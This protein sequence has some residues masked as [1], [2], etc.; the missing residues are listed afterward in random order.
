M[1]EIQADPAGQPIRIAVCAALAP[2]ILKMAAGMAPGGVELVPANIA[3]DGDRALGVVAESEFIF[4][5]PEGVPTA[6][7]QAANRVKLIQMLSAGYDNMDSRLALSRGIPIA[8]NGGAN[9]PSVAEHTVL[10]ILALYRHLVDK[11]L[12]VRG[13]G[14]EAA[15]SARKPSRELTG[16]TVGLLGVGFIGRAVAARVRGFETTIIYHDVRRMQPEVEKELGLTY[17]ERAELLKRAD[18]ISLHLPLLP[19]TRHIIGEAELAAMKPEA[20]LVNTARG[21]LVDEQALARALSEQRILGAAL[22]VMAEEP[23]SPDHPLRTMSNCL[24]TPHAAGLTRENWP[25]RLHNAFANVSRVLAGD[26]PAWL[27]QGSPQRR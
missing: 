4:G 2:H 3:T 20:I 7:V 14:W 25:R 22:D 6:V 27:I 15:T 1:T 11:A 13:G 21:E 26:T 17:M 12:L 16:K 10:L 8:T 19:D 18:V 23:P 5:F 24:I 9:A